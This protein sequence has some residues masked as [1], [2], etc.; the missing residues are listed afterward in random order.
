MVYPRYSAM[1][2]D[3]QQ[4][5]DSLEQSYFAQQKAIEEKALKL[6]G[7]ARVAYLTG[8]TCQKADEM[9]ARWRQLAWFLVV[10]HNDMAVRPIGDNGQFL[11][12]EH[13]LGKTVTRPGYPEEYRRQLLRMTGDRYLKPKE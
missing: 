5:R 10:R 8:Y 9:I 2:P 12:G 6:E 7:D 1:F 4:V 3:L 11:R 13:G